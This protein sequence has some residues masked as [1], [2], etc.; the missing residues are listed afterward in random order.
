MMWLV[1]QVLTRCWVVILCQEPGEEEL[2][3]SLDF[4]FTVG[5]LAGLQN[6]ERVQNKGTFP[7]AITERNQGLAWMVLGPFS[8]QDA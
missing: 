6:E 7:S 1:F 4:H 2:I 8:S 3:L 5:I